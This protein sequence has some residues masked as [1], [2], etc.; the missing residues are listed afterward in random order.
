MRRILNNVII[1]IL[2]LFLF[3]CPNFSLAEDEETGD[4]WGLYE[5]V[6]LW[7]KERGDM[8]EQLPLIKM[9][10][11]NI[12]IELNDD[13]TAKLSM[14]DESMELAFDSEAMTL[15][16]S[17]G[18]PFEFSIENGLIVLED[19]ENRM[20]FSK[21]NRTEQMHPENDKSEQA[22]S[23][24]QYE[25]ISLITEKAG[26]M[27]EE[28]AMMKEFGLV[29]TFEVYENN[30]AE[31]N[32][33]GAKIPLKI[34]TDNMIMLDENGDPVPF[35][36]ADGIITIAEDGNSMSFAPVEKDISSSDLAA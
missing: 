29:V 3:F 5:I 25:M 10:G 11:M 31:L 28:L 27:T 16:G 19:D 1:S 8:T 13:G 4:I 18:I 14:F 20:A 2:C 22:L 15:T 12:T 24:G 32:L 6:E 36:F 21:M 17:N 33:F 35:I 30:T 9:L 7:S 34:D 23:I 26:D